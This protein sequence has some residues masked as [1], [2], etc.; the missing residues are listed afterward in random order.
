MRFS[1]SQRFRGYLER[2]WF[3][4]RMRKTARPVVWE[5]G[6]AQS[7]SLHPIPSV[8]FPRT[9][10]SFWA[11]PT[12][13]VGGGPGYRPTSQTYSMNFELGSVATDPFLLKNQKR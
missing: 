10:R 8:R 9:V 1:V 3:N 13:G 4:R 12:L 2:R 5:G 11:A 7:P 6:G